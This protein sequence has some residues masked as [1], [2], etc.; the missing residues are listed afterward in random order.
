MSAPG[1]G[2]AA[3]PPRCG[4]QVPACSPPG[5]SPP[6]TRRAGAR[7]GLQFG[8]FGRTGLGAV[9]LKS[10]LASV[11]LGVAVCRSCWRCGSTGSCR[12][13]AGPRARSAGAPGAGLRP[14]R[15]YRPDRPALPHRLRR[16]ADQR[17]VAVHSLAGCF[18]YGAFVAKVLLV[19]SRRLPGWA[20]PVAG[21][22]SPSSSAF[23]GTPPRCGTTTASSYRAIGCAVI[24]G[25]P[26][27]RQ[28][29]GRPGPNPAR[30]VRRAPSQNGSCGKADQRSG[31]IP[32]GQRYL[33]FSAITTG[34]PGRCARPKAGVLSPCA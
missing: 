19:H 3:G 13:R 2:G 12:G 27:A 16:A 4:W 18:L 10:V 15:A 26:R 33:L 25:Q 11:V 29:P 22:R 34:T 32:A 5:W 24:P 8:L 20:L 9:S 30:R 17:R 14:V 23:S 6:C 21:A 31:R 28:P 7:A 1:S